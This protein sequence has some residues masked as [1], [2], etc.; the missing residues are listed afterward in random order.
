MH[1]PAT[2]IV[3]AS[4][5]ESEGSDLTGIDVSAPLPAS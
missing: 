3:F 2:T 5:Y 1:R 4:Y